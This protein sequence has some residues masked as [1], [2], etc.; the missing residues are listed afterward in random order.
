[1][2]ILDIHNNTV[3]P[4]LYEKGNAIMW[5]DTH[6][7]KQLLDVHLNAELDLG[8]RKAETINSTVKWILESCENKQLNILD[9]GC[10]PGLY[11]E[12]LAKEGHKV[13]GVDFSENS[14]NYAKDQARE[15]KLDITYLKEDYLNLDLE[16]NSF[17]LV[18]LIF[19][20]FG[21][22]LPKE[23][24]QLL[25]NVK[26]FLKPNGTF[27]FDV[28]NDKNIENKISPKNWET[29]DQGFWKD[30]PY[31]ALSE[32]FIY[33]SNKVILYQHIVVDTQENISVYRFW[34]HFFSQIDLRKILREHNFIGLSFHE[35]ILPAGDLWNGDN[36]TFCRAIN[37]K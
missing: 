36:V 11:S 21:P 23:R 33:E 6:I 13:T 34:T 9:L 5:T 31:L 26:R 25:I 16:E 37:R 2:K 1:M 22:L 4:K 32:S 24:E 15:K 30:E 19:T 35:D 10:G 12:R 20:D 28:L 14:I 8:S 3:R 29:A 18:I 7:S 27:I 17:D